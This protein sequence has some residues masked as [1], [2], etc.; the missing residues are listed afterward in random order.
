MTIAD[1]IVQFWV[2]D[3]GPK[4]WYMGTEELDGT[5]RAQFQSHWQ[6]ALEGG[7]LDWG[8]TARGALAYLILTDQF[9]RNMFR[10][11]SRAFAT[12]E[13]ARSMTRSAIEQGFDLEIEGEER[14][15]FYMPFEHSEDSYDQELSISLIAERMP[16]HPTQLLH[17]KAHQEVIRKFGRFPYRNNALLRASS[18]EET[19]F[20]LN[21][22]Y[23]MIIRKLDKKA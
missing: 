15:F 20:M 13:L 10:D 1:K 21:G 9:P 14:Q 4:G 2:H 12:D 11:D 19:D 5:I 6:M 16:D 18:D 22:G 7:Y 23:Q 3:T 8:Q 17:A